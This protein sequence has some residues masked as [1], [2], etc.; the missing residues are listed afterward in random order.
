VHAHRKIP[1]NRRAAAL[2]GQI[3]GSE[4]PRSR[5]R[6]LHCITRPRIDQGRPSQRRARS[7]SP[8]AS[9]ARTPLLLMRSPS[10]VTGPSTSTSNPR[11]VPASRQHGRGRLAIASEAKVVTDYHDPRAQLARQELRK[12]FTREVTQSLAEAQQPQIMQAGA[13][14]DPPALAERS[15]P[16]GRIIRRQVLA[17]RGLERPSEPRPLGAPPRARKGVPASGLVAEVN[18]VVGAYGQHAAAR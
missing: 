13:R 8:R 7:K 10:S 18:A 17:R 12:G 4:T 9:A 1:A 16:R 14:E 11:R 6:R 15:E 3:G 5:P 2:E